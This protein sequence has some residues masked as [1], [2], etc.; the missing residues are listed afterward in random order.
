[1]SPLSVP[2]PQTDV[3]GALI[4]WL[5]Q[6]HTAALATV[7]S[8]WGSSPC[9]PGSH[10]AIRDDGAIIGSVS[11][12]CVESAVVHEAMEAI[13]GAPPAVS[14]FGVTG[15][16]AWEVGLACGGEIRVLV[17]RV[18]NDAA[19][20]R[21]A[22]KRAGEGQSS[23]LVTRISDGA[24][25]LI[26]A[27]EKSGSLD[28]S[29]ELSEA[30]GAAARENRSGVFEDGDEAFFIEALTPPKRLIIVGAVHIAQTLVPMARMA[31][32]EVVVVDPREAFATPE[33]FPDVELRTDWPDEALLD[34]AVNDHTA[35]VVLTHDP[36]IDDPV[37]QAA[38]MSP[39]FYVGALGSLRTQ[40]KRNKRLEERGVEPRDIARLHGPV[41]LD[42][43]SASPAEIAVSILAEII[44][45]LRRG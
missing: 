16:M 34:L 20:Y 5:D 7:I 9:P 2:S 29:P 32:F 40:E 26:G 39:A 44:Q 22:R 42:I 35:V 17:R 15:D 43:G 6:G 13:N 45:E 31:G 38:L 28:V 18:E 11:A 23:A 14:E 36:K 25:V 10:L 19:L 12:G 33:R 41:G 4:E 27:G 1:M 8:T 30:A 3:I 37:L 21:A 24:S